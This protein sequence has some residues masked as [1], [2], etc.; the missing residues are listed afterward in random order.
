MN[1]FLEANY[2]VKKLLKAPD[3]PEATQTSYGAKAHTI[4]THP[5]TKAKILG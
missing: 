2:R 1:S 4:V 5:E 3:A